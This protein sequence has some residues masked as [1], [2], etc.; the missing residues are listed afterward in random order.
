MFTIINV[1]TLTSPVSS[2]MKGKGYLYIVCGIE[3]R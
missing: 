3:V 1:G 2:S